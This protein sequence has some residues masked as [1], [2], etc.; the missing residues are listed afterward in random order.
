[1]WSIFNTKW[2]SQMIYDSLCWIWLPFYDIILGEIYPMCLKIKS[3]L[4]SI[5]PHLHSKLNLHHKKTP[6]ILEYL[7]KFR[8][9][10]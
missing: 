2:Y 7:M 6:D 4:T 9:L 3:N 8:H 1:M 10:E 5:S